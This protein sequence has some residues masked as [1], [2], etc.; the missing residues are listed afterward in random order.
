MR[1]MPNSKLHNKENSLALADLLEQFF[2]CFY[3]ESL[4][5]RTIRSSFSSFRLTA[6]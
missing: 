6:K 2:K 3:K 5:I 4:L 1:V